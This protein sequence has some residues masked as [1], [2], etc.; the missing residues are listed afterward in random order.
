MQVV[1]DLVILVIEPVVFTVTTN[2]IGFSTHCDSVL[3]CVHVICGQPTTK[4]GTK[5]T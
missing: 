1:S 3:R 4:P 2:T 5:Q